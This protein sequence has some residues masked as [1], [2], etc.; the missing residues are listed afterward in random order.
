[1]LALLAP[2]VQ[3]ERVD[4]LAPQQGADFA[5]TRAGIGLGQDA[6]FLLGAESKALGL[7]HNFRV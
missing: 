1:M 4:A 2:L 6:Q 7:G 5:R 3:M